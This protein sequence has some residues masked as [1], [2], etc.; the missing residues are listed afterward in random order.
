MTPRHVVV[1]MSFVV[2]VFLASAPSS[3]A[4]G[5]PIDQPEFLYRGE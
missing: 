5:P 2:V 4:Q 3:L 1:L